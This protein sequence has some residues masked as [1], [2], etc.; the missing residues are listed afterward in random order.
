MLFLFLLRGRDGF[1]GLYSQG[2]SLELCYGC[3]FS[4]KQMGGIWPF[5][6]KIYRIWIQQG[7]L[8]HCYFTLNTNTKKQT[9]ESLHGHGDTIPSHFTL[10]SI[11]TSQNKAVH[12]ITFKKMALLYLLLLYLFSLIQEL[13]ISY[14]PICFSLLHVIC[15]QTFSGM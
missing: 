14:I 13:I 15:L 4:R 11:L 8:V 3:H 9:S 1:K 5:C 2:N 6:E 10:N 12:F 7:N